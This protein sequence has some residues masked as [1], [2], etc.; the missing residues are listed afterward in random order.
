MGAE[1]GAVMTE[2]HSTAE[3]EA[4]LKA[5]REAR[6]SGQTS[7]RKK[8]GPLEKEWNY[9]SDAEMAAAIADLERRLGQTRPLNIVVRSTKGW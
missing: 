4:Q 8:I 3:L 7:F 2:T 6:A 1:R 9:R 5:L